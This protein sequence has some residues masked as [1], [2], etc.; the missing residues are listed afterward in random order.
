MNDGNSQ[1]Y[2]ACEACSNDACRTLAQRIREA[3]IAHSANSDKRARGVA[4]SFEEYQEANWLSL[5][6]LRAWDAWDK[7]LR[8]T[9][10][11]HT[12]RS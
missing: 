2:A 1:F 3:T 8:D 12:R 10:H 4:T 6:R 9:G 7:F 5:E 11:Q